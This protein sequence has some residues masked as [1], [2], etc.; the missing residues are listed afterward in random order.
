MFAMDNYFSSYR[1]Y[2]QIYYLSHHAA[3]FVFLINELPNKH[4]FQSSGFLKLPAY[5][6][7]LI[8]KLGD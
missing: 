1:R 8:S 7:Y 6:K 5:L 3:T 2:V 4:K